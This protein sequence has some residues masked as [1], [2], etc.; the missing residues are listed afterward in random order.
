MNIK[1]FLMN[2]G[3]EVIARV[4]EDGGETFVVEQPYIVQ[5]QANQNNINIGMGPMCVGT[6]P[7]GSIELKKSALVSNFY[8]APS[9]LEKEYVSKTS[10][11]KLA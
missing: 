4:V 8:D 9:Q 3:I 6:F 2:G 11:I 1:M 5:L 10:R 7:E